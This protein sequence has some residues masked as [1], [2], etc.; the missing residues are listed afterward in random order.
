MTHF[1]PFSGSIANYFKDHY[2]ILKQ[3]F[4]EHAYT[5]LPTDK[6][7]HIFEGETM[8]YYGKIK[9]LSFKLSKECI[10]G[11]ELKTLK[12]DEQNLGKTWFK[13]KDLYPES[14]EKMDNWQKKFRP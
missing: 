9:V 10:S 7:N 4:Y 2:T 6:P 11:K 12:W 5:N 3:E 14:W 1:K 13:F 8:L